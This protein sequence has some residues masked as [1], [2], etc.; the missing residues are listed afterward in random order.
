MQPELRRRLKKV[1]GIDPWCPI[2]LF[3]LRWLEFFL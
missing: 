3:D 1:T 2:E